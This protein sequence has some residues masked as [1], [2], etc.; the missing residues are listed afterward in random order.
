MHFLGGVQHVLCRGVSDAESAFH[1]AIPRV[2]LRHGHR[3]CGQ[4]FGAVLRL[5]PAADATAQPGLGLMMD[6]VD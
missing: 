3:P 1:R 2:G 5:A 6:L 4:G